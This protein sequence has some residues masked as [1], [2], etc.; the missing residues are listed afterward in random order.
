MVWLRSFAACGS[1]ANPG[2]IAGEAI[3]CQG[4]TGVGYSVAPVANA[5]GYNWTLPPGA[6]VVSGN[7]TNAI[8]V[9]YSTG[10]TSGSIAVNGMNGCG[11]APPSQL[12]VTVNPLPVANAGPD[13]T[14]PYGTSITLHA[15]AGGSGTLS[16]H[17]SPEALLVNPNLQD[18]QTVNLTA[19]TVFILLVTNQASLCEKTDDVVVTITGGPLHA[20]PVSIP[21]TVCKG[22]PSQLF[23]NAGGGSGTYTYTWS[24]NPPGNPPWNS[25][26]AN[27]TVFPDVSTTYLLNLSDGFNGTSG[28]TTVL[29][30]PLPTAFIQGG[31]TLCGSGNST[32][33]T[34][35]LTGSPPWLFY[36]SNGITTWL[37]QAQYATP[38]II[39]ATE[40]GVYTVL[41]VSDEHCAGTTSGSAPVAVFPIPPAPSININGTEISS[42]GCCGNQWY[43]DGIPIPGATG[44]NYE[45]LATA[46]YFTIVTV[47]GCSSDTS[48]TIYY[49]MT[50]I[51]QP[52]GQKFF[53]RVKP[54]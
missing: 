4:V 2:P 14:I 9:N 11:S 45:P 19:T 17:W 21:N 6:T 26:L 20:S 23:A 8:T 30:H 50:G 42:T 39:T 35:D 41:A 24:S 53:H 51:R 1:I 44:Q 13:V 25:S 54:G 29:V 43:R 32:I 12:P 31:D 52:E 3:I 38:Y 27:P 18:P 5:T 7:N 46:H 33:L 10:A 28:N 34:V 47:D 40:P 16:Y 49:F 37:V 48:N 36:Y 15:S 22:T